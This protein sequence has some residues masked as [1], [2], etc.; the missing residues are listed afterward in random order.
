M[1]S[2][3]DESQ[4]IDITD[5]FGEYLRVVLVQKSD[6]VSVLTVECGALNNNPSGG[7]TLVSA[8]Q[9]QRQHPGSYLDASYLSS[10][11]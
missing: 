10:L 1:Y 6:F 7:S 4:D 8:V 9:L 2:S 5:T 11:D 3:D